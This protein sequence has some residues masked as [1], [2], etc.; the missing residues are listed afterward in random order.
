MRSACSCLSAC[1]AVTLRRSVV[2]S[3]A[4]DACAGR[5]RPPNPAALRRIRHR[6]PRPRTPRRPPDHVS[7]IEGAARLDREGEL[8]DVE[9]GVPLVAGDRLRT[10][11]GRVEITL[12]DGTRLHLDRYSEIELASDLVVRLARGRLLVTMQRRRRRS[13]V[14]RSARRAGALRRRRA[15][16]HRRRRRRRRRSRARRAARIGR[17][18]RATRGA[19]RLGTGERSR[20]RDGEAP[21][22]PRHRSPRRRRP[23]SAGPTS[24]MSDELAEHDVADLSPVRARSLRRARSIA[25]APGRPTRPTATCW[26]PS[27]EADW[28][29]VLQRPLGSHAR[30]RLDVD[31]R[32]PVG[33]SDA[34]LRPLAVE[35]AR[36]VVLDPVAPLGTGL[37]L[38]GDDAHLCRLVSARLERPSRRERV[39][40]RERRSDLRARPRSRTAPGRSC[41]RVTSVGRRCRAIA[42]IGRFS[43][44]SSRGS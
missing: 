7:A 11:A 28:R 8:T 14:G 16:P 4:G 22:R 42:S 33:L 29:P 25:M 1:T 34:P 3:A 12:T 41:R 37:G 5:R 43:I 10:E 23:S 40:L 39:R 20:V 30:L 17:A 44:A 35:R 6:P 2:G 26:Y 13:R 38:L 21:S 9:R 32:R 19:V 24:S 27:V 15:V 36:S 18:R 31:C